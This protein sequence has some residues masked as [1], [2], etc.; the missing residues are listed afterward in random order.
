MAPHQSPKPRTIHGTPSGRLLA[1]SVESSIWFE[2]QVLR[3]GS[4]CRRSCR[5]VIRYNSDRFHGKFIVK[6]TQGAQPKALVFVKIRSYVRPTAGDEQ[7][8]QL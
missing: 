8:N 5:S 7:Y 4:M 6:G 3:A 2:L 1:L